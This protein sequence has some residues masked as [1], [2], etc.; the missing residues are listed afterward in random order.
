MLEI[1]AIMKTKDSN[2]SEETDAWNGGF[3]NKTFYA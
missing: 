2:I 3:S 1:L